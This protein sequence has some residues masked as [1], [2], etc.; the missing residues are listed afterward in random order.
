[1]H[2]AIVTGVS[3]GLGASLAT[4]LLEHGFTVLGI[5]RA[6]GPAPAGA[7]FRFVR[8]DLADA[9]RIDETIAPEFSALAA[10]R[11]ASVCLINNAATAGPVGTL[12]TLAAADVIGSLA[13]NLAAVVAISN[14]FCRLFTDPTQLRRIINVSSGAAQTALAGESLYCVAKAGMEMLTRALAVEQMAPTFRAISL[15]PGIIDTDMQQFARSQPREAL[16][17]VD[18]FREFHS[19]GRLVPP[20]VVAAKIVDKLVLGEVEHGRTYSYQEL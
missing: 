16:P 7:R 6:P 11:P 5:G 1:M 18:M 14:L 10:T 15:R 9:A 17:C 3:R 8:F 13:V 4:A 20:D 2:A 19:Q 12:G